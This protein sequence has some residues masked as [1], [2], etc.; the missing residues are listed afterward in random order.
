MGL[1]EKRRCKKFF[2]YAENYDPGNPK[3]FEKID[4]FNQPFGDLMRKFSL[5]QNTIDF[6]GHAVALYSNDSF[7]SLPCHEVL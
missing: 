7:L 4:P 6:I 1:M 2:K 3:T 5:E